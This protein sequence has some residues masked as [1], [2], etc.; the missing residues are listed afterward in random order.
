MESESGSNYFTFYKDFYEMVYTHLDSLDNSNSLK[1]DTDYIYKVFFNLY[2]HYN[3]Q[4]DKNKGYFKLDKD[5][6]Y[7]FIQDA[8]F[9]I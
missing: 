6:I 5:L 8:N 1:V 7:K 9:Q 3:N 4:K 2:H